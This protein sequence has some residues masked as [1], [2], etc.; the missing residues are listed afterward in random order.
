MRTYDL[1]QDFAPGDSSPDS[2]TVS[3]NWVLALVRLKY[4]LTYR[5]KSQASFSNFFPDAVEVRGKTLIINGDCVQ[6]QVQSNKSNHLSNLSA[7]LLPGEVNYL[8]E[9]MPG[10]YLAAWMLNDEEKTQD[11]I[12]RIRKGEA[13]NHFMDG[14]KFFGKAQNIQKQLTQS[15]DGNR[16]VTQLCIMTPTYKK[17]YRLSADSLDVLRSLLII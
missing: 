8:S 5:R 15:P 7:S 16:N 11:L 13:C 3:A 4:P 6:L 10:D 17:R 14:L 12:K 9:I 2:I 1:L